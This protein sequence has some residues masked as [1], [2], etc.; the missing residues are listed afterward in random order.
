MGNYLTH[1]NLIAMEQREERDMP[2]NNDTLK[3]YE[4]FLLEVDAFSKIPEDLWGVHTQSSISCWQQCEKKYEYKYE[5]GYRSAE[6]IA[7]YLIGSAVH[8]GLEYFWESMPYHAAVTAVN[9]FF[10]E[11]ATYFD[12]DGALERAKIIAYI[13]GYY[14]KWTP[15]KDEYEVIS[16]ELRFFK[17]H[18]FT[19]W[20]GW[21]ELKDW[22]Q[23]TVGLRIS[24][25]LDV[26]LRRRIDGKLF[27]MEHKTAGAYSKAD[28]PGSTYWMKLA[29]DTQLILYKFVLEAISGEEVGVIY[30]VVMKSGMRLLK[31]KARKRASESELDFAMRKA[32]GAET[33]SQFQGRINEVYMNEPERYQR[34]EIHHTKEELINKMDELI[35]IM[36]RINRTDLRVRNTTNCNS[37]GSPCE[38]LGVC[39]GIEQLDDPKFEKKEAMHEELK[40]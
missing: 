35:N 31:G 33:L 29:M 5:K 32:E 8:I 22:E 23:A 7:A 1:L 25:K 30:D 19:Q 14:H 38:F 2:K 18:D 4:G 34:R 13:K 21:E 36:N 28:E 26:L 27:I 37:Y 20:F 15:S 10:T 24:G 40:S 9:E 11:N 6:I 39:T 12:G 17:E 3:I 16:A